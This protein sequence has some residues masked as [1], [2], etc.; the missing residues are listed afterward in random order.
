MN[1]LLWLHFGAADRE[2]Q[3]APLK[4]AVLLGNGCGFGKYDLLRLSPVCPRRER[5]A[6]SVGEAPFE[7]GFLLGVRNTD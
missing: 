2:P 7:V 5:I 6:W 1:V 4:A 3:T